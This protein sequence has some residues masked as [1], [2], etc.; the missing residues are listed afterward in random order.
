MIYL[1]YRMRLTPHAQRDM[2]AFWRWLEERE[3]WFYRDLPMVKGVRWF[4]SVVGELYILEC[5]AAFESESGWVNYRE[6]IAARKRNTSWEMERAQQLDW[7][8]FLDS[9]IVTDP[10]SK[11]GFGQVGA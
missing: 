11:I 10:P 2:D 8:E 3:R 7:W 5:W 1:V 4:A 6:T 9:R